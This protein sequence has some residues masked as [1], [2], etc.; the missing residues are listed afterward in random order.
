MPMSINV[1]SSKKIGLPG[2]GSVGATCNVTFEADHNLLDRNLEEFH[3]RVK[4]AFAACRLAVQGQL[5]RE[6]NAT[7]NNGGAVRKP[8][9]AVT[10]NGAATSR[11]IRTGNG[12]CNDN[13]HRISNKQLS[14][15]RKLSGQIEG[16]GICRLDVIA[17]K[18]FSKPLA[19][20]SILDGS[21]LIE[22]LQN[23]KAGK[24]DLDKVLSGGAA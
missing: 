8:A 12:D 13:G 23:V 17:S 4:H 19:D 15:I 21:G 7:A 6:T 18:M 22:V 16:L 20:L 1:G 9:K 24:I 3:Q 11:P 10:G 14:F 2:F 5:A